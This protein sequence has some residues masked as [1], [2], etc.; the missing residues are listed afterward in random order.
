[1]I[2]TL[3]FSGC[4]ARVAA[5]DC[6]LCQSVQKCGWEV[7]GFADHACSTSANDDNLLSAILEQFFGRHGRDVSSGRILVAMNRYLDTGEEQLFEDDES[8]E[9][10]MDGQVGEREEEMESAIFASCGFA[11]LSIK[12]RF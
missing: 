9:V 4:R 10:Y 5:Q 2:V 8:G 3:Y 7:L 11:M 6:K 12:G 1:M